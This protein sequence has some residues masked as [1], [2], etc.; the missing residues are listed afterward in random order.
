MNPPNPFGRRFEKIALGIGQGKFKVDPV[1][2]FDVFSG[3]GM[4][5]GRKSIACSMR[6]RASDRTLS[7]KEL[8]QAFESVIEKIEVETAYELRK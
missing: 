3:K 5:E 6:F 2:V 8:N 4:K 7:E 1:G